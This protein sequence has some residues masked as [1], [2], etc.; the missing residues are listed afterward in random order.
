MNMLLGKQQLSSRELPALKEEKSGKPLK[1]NVSKIMKLTSPL[2]EL[3]PWNAEKRLRLKPRNGERTTKL[4]L[5]LREFLLR[6]QEKSVMPPPLSKE[7]NMKLRLLLSVKKTT[8][9]SVSLRCSSLASSAST[10]RE[11][12]LRSTPTSALA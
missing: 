12:S 6:N 7:K 10:T 1:R 5:K 2:K 4:V 8:S 9:S 3:L 11:T